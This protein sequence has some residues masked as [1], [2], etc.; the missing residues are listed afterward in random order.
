MFDKAIL[1]DLARRLLEM[2]AQEIIAQ[3]HKATGA[4]IDSFENPVRDIPNGI[5]I[6]GRMNRYGL[7]LEKKRQPG[8]PPPISAL[9]Q[10]VQVKGLG[11]TNKSVRSI[12]YA[13]QRAIMLEGIPTTGRKTPNGKGAFRFSKVGR[14]T[15]WI[16]TVLKEAEPLIDRAGGKMADKEA[17]KII[18]N[19][20]RRF[21]K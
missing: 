9:I 12:A 5:E 1:T 3:G 19:L 13:I 8:K 4:L 18:D 20:V 15:A 16:T 14:R 11:S 17:E 7:A 21:K 6:E 2:E 10:W